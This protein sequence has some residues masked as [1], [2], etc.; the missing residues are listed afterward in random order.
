MGL[1]DGDTALVTGVASGIGRGIAKAL[2]AEGVRLVL[3]D[4]AGE[5]GQALARE[6]DAAFV[7]ADL[8]DPPAARRLFDVAARELGPVSILV[9]SASPKRH[10]SETALAVTE[11]QWDAMVDV[12][13]RSGFVLGQAAGAHM[14]ARKIKGRIL[15]ITSLHAY[16]PRNLPHYSATKAGQT[17]VMKELARALGSAGIRVNAIAPGAIPGGGFAA[18]VAALE[19]MIPLGR[20]GTP[21]DIAGMAVALLCDRFSRYVTGTTVA[22]D[23][24]LALYNWIPFPKP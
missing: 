2:A 3:S 18:D 7:P 5:A 17:M 10:E 21:E 1:L 20:T 14:K 16:S 8:T 22:V 12:G 19:K 24:G 13:L 11:D 23:G 15:F 4:I 6:L 9:H